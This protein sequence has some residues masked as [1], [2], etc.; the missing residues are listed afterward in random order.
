MTLVH[1][2]GLWL[3]YT[4]EFNENL[5]AILKRTPEAPVRLIE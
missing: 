5:S 3:C 1:K 2:N 4:E